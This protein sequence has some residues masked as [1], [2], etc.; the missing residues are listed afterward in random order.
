[1]NKTGSKTEESRC[2][3]SYSHSHAFFLAYLHFGQDGNNWHD[4]A[5]DEIE[6]DEGFVR[7][8]VVRLSV[9]DV[10]QHNGSKGRAIEGHR[11]GEQS[12]NKMDMHS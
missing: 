6:A 2:S 3:R 8:A 5:E 11:E 9:V 10:E 1:M 7:G 12:C 4:D